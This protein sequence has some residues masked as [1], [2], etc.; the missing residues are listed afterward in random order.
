M[1]RERALRIVQVLTGLIFVAGIY[2]PITSVRDGWHAKFS[3]VN[4]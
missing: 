3:Q 2:P 4:E 1:V